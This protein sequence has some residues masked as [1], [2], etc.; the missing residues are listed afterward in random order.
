MPA[1]TTAEQRSQTGTPFPTRSPLAQ[2]ANY[3]MLF[4]GGTGVTREGSELTLEYVA[5]LPTVPSAVR[6]MWSCADGV[7]SSDSKVTGVLCSDDSS[8]E[9]SFTDIVPLED[10][11][12]CSRAR[13]LRLSSVVYS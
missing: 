10:F 5:V 3:D 6:V 11:R 2:Y 12:R 9:R 8:V 7:R 1:E 13:H 4:R